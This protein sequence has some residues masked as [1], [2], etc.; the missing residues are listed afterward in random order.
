MRL[1][2]LCEI[3]VHVAGPVLEG[4][5]PQWCIACGMILINRGM[6]RWPAGAT[7]AVPRP[8]PELA[9]RFGTVPPWIMSLK[10]YEPTYP[11]RHCS[12]AN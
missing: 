10:P 4:Y 2:P 5:E 12:G 6:P 3:P 9:E 7:I 8:A 11:Y 1:S